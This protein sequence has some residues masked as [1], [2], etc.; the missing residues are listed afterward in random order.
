MIATIAS[1]F[2]LRSG[3]SI[4]QPRGFCRAVALA[5][6]RRSSGSSGT[7]SCSPTIAL[8]S[9]AEAGIALASVCGQLDA[10]IPRSASS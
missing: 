5:A 2:E 10:V 7:V 3:A 4:L 8:R 1:M 6:W 9:R